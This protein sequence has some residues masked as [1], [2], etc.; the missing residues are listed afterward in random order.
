MLSARIEVYRNK[1]QEFAKS[2]RPL[3]ESEDLAEQEEAQAR[4][5][6]EAAEEGLQRAH[7]VQRAGE[8]VE[9]AQ[10]LAEPAAGAEF[11]K[12]QR[13]AANFQNILQAKC[14]P[15]SRHRTTTKNAL[16]HLH[17]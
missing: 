2:K 7:E 10:E 6:L 8:A 4:G 13:R 3:I 1:I 12:S 5:V 15:T 9:A 11:A 16:K 17:K 14:R